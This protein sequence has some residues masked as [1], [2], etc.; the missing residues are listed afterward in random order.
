[1]EVKLPVVE[2]DKGVKTNDWI[3][4]KARQELFDQQEKI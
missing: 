1:M 3:A 2:F 4:D